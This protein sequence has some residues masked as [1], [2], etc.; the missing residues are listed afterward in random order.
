MFYI[1]GILSVFDVSG[2]IDWFYSQFD[3]VLPVAVEILCVN[4]KRIV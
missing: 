1:F 3:V 2:I 4:S